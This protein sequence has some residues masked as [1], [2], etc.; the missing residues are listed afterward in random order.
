V[1]RSRDKTPA[2]RSPLTRERVFEAAMRL[3][4]ADGLEGMSMR[5]LGQALGVEAMTL[6]HHVGRKEQ[7]IGA[8]LERVYAEIEPADPTSDWRSAIHR[9]AVSAHHA[10]GRH[11]WAIGYFGGIGSVGRFQLAYMDALLQRLRDAGFSPILTHH[12]YHVLDSH[13]VGSIL[14][15]AGYEQAARREPDMAARAM[16]V[17]PLADYPAMAEH[18]EQHISG[19]AARGVPTF[20]FGLDL[21]LDGLERLLSE[22]AVD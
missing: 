14:W 16:D 12:A 22:R 19:A 4:D 10:F 13:I 5:R 3:A 17:L 11:P 15:A 6:Y 2:R 9:S 20:D 21:I 8:L 7:L 1:P 18:V